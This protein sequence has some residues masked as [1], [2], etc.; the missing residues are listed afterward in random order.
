MY[1]YLLI[2]QCQGK[3]QPAINSDV[4]SCT[5]QLVCGLLLVKSLELKSSPFIRTRRFNLIDHSILINLFIKT[6]LN[7]NLPATVCLNMSAKF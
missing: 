1:L 4:S 3:K 6:G 7:F 2:N 5:S